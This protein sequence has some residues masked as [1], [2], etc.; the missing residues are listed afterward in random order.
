MTTYT[1]RLDLTFIQSAQAQKHVI[2]NAALKRL[3]IVVQQFEA[4]TPA[5][6]PVDGQS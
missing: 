5:I 4:T 2:H 6:S 1:P 3:D